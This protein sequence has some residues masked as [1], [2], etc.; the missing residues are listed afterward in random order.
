[1]KDAFDGAAVSDEDQLPARAITQLF[2]HLDDPVRLQWNPIARH[3]FQDPITG[4]LD[5]DRTRAAILE[6]RRLVLNGLELAKDAD[7]MRGRDRQAQRQ[8]TIIRKLYFDGDR[9]QEVAKYLGI[10]ARQLYRER[11]QICARIAAHIWRNRLEG[12]AYIAQ[13]FTPFEFEVERAQTSAEV[14]NAT[15]AYAILNALLAHCPSDL[16]KADVTCTAASIAVNFG[17]RQ[18]ARKNIALTR[19]FLERARSDRDVPMAQELIVGRLSLVS[20]T[21]GRAEGDAER[22]KLALDRALE[23]ANC[24]N[25]SRPDSARFCADVAFERA[26]TL[27]QDG[28]FVSAKTILNAASLKPVIAL[29]PTVSRVDLQM[30]LAL[31]SLT[32][33]AEP[34]ESPVGLDTLRDALSRARSCGSSRLALRAM[35]GIAVYLVHCGMLGEAARAVQAVITMAIHFPNTR[36]RAQTLVDA[37]DVLVVTS[38]YSDVIKLLDEADSFLVEGNADWLGSKILRARSYNLGRAYSDA[39]LVALEVEAGA[40]R[41]GSHRFLSAAWREMAVAA[42][43]CGNVADASERITAAIAELEHG[44]PPIAA[45]STYQAAATI[46]RE[47][48]WR[49]RARVLERELAALN[50]A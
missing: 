14:G 33:A 35:H 28:Q 20:A 39:W 50:D 32:N 49:N 41:L 46:T 4:C 18:V 45:L 30:T 24:L 42:Y 6:L 23:I 22:A 10:S 1:M 43:A 27:L 7:L 17:E 37:A 15:E 29:I 5:T 19:A 25:A 13:R 40:Q 31:L 11:S 38:G 26:E 34:G 3:L 9:V 47:A 36:V 21:L 16:V 2:R 44:A 8:Y 12:R 48:R